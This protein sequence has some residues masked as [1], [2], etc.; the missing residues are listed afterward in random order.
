[1]RRTKKKFNLTSTS[2]TLER[3]SEKWRSTV[4]KKTKK[5]IEE[6][7]NVQPPSPQLYHQHSEPVSIQHE[8]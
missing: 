2:S 5:P 4:G 7:E 3:F 8:F 1:M 6:S